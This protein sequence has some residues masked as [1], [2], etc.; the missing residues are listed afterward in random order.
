MILTKIEIEKIENPI[1]Q[2]VA[3]VTIE[4]NDCLRITHLKIIKGSKGL[5]VAM[6]SYKYDDGYKDVCYFIGQDLNNEISNQIIA[7]YMTEGI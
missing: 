1:N 4:I 5:F 3:R 6:P 2:C 7:K